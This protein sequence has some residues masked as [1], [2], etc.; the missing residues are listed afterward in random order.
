M[1]G[2]PTLLIDDGKF[3][4]DNLRRERI[5]EDDIMMAIREHGLLEVAAVKMAVLGTDGT[6]SI[7][8]GDAKLIRTRKLPRFV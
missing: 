7:V 3:I 6:I 1:E 5:L 2:T 8:P 4:M